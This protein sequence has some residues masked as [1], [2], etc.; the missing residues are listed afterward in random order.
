MSEVLE[1]GLIYFLYRPR[2]DHEEVRGLDDV[3]R[4]H[5]VLR[6]RDRPVWR[7]LQVGRKRLPAVAPGH[8]RF[9]AFIDKVAR[10]PG[11]L[12]SELAGQTYQT[13]TR[14]QRVQPPA[15]PAGEGCYLLV[16]HGAHTHL[17]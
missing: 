7:M 17:A 11:E 12:E 8:E 2:V 15:R 9:W 13:K 3:Q 6:P 5:L 4:F 16:G 1:R 14:G 10:S